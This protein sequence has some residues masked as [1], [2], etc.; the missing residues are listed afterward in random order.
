MTGSKVKSKSYQDV[1]DQQFLSNV[2][3]KYQLPQLMVSEML[4]R[5]NLKGHGHYSKIKGLIKAIP[6]RFTPAT[7][8]Q[9]PYQVS[10]SCTLRLPRYRM[11]KTL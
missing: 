10:T 2:P 1:A 3:T 11:D 4:P 6:R 7:Y 8:N 9:S 5:Q